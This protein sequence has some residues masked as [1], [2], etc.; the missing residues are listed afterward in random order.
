MSAPP[1]LGSTPACSTR[2][3]ASWSPSLNAEPPP[4]G[5]RRKPSVKAAL[6]RF[7]V[8]GAV[9]VGINQLVLFALH[10]VVGLHLLVASA[11]A[12]ECAILGNYVGNELFTFHHR[13][14]AWRRA[15]RFNLVSLGSLV[16]TV[17]ALWALQK[18]TP[19]HYLVDNLIAIAVGASWNFAVNFGWTWR[20]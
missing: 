14:L 5:V 17:G 11:L 12:T 10:G 18:L 20:T 4:A 7:A 13:R 16:L 2:W 19:L 3:T 9:G 15:G 6:P 8:V 1:I